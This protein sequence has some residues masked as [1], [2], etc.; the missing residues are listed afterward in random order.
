MASMAVEG[1]NEALVRSAHDG[2][3]GEGKRRTRSGRWAS[4]R[5]PSRRLT[6]SAGTWQTTATLLLQRPSYCEA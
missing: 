5:P 2:D 3:D 6:T 1:K 4:R